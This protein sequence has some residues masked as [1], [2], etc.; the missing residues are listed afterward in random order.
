MK[1]IVIDYLIKIGFSS[2][3]AKIY[4]SLL[5]L[6]AATVKEISD[7]S[8][9]NRITVHFNV[10]RLIEKGIISQSKKGSKRLIYIESPD[11]IKQI[12]DQKIN[13][14]RQYQ[15]NLPKII[16]FIKRHYTFVDQ[17]TKKIEL[18]YFLGKKEVAQIY[19]DILKAKEL[20]SY[21][22][23]KSVAEVFPNNLKLF[24]LGMKR[25]PNL[26]FWE[27]VEDSEI[28]R[29]ETK[30]FAKNPRY[31]YKITSAI[32]LSS[33]DVMIFDGKVVVVNLKKEISATLFYNNEYYF[34]SKEIFDFVWRM[35]P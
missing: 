11:K 13:L 24:V 25:N 34:M 5:V 19:N 22:N 18:K 8:G 6:G 35:I 33:A 16:D 29:K 21:V 17:N 15:D 31:Q 3:E 32:N 4:Q 14:F 1:D 2:I 30:I 27:I 10:E 9:I 28:A 20:R 12:I 26:K 23:L 7:Y